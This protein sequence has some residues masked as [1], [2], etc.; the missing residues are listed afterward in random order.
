M[1]R[2]DMGHHQAPQRAWSLDDILEFE[3]PAA[4]LGRDGLPYLVFGSNCLSWEYAELVFGTEFTGR[5]ASFGNYEN[6]V[7]LQEAIGL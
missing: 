7:L 5:I 3:K 6:A 4:Q 2:F 1:S